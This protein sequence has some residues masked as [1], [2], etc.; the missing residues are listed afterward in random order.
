[1]AREIRHV[2][3]MAFSLMARRLRPRFERDFLHAS[4]LTPIGQTDPE[5]IFV[6]GYPKSGNTWFQNLIA[7]LVFGVDLEYARDT[8]VQELTPD[9]HARLYYKRF[10]VPMYFKSHHLPCPE[11]RRVIYLLRD[12]RDALVSYYH[13]LTAMGGKEVDLATMISTGEGLFPSKW[14]EHVTAWLANPYQADMMVVK[15]EDLMD[16]GLRQ[17]SK[18]CEFANIY[19]DERAIT[20]ALEDA[21]FSNMRHREETSG[22]DDRG[23]WPSDKHFVRRGKIGSYK[24]EMPV[25][26]Q[27][28]FISQAGPVLRSCGY[29][30]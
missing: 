26:V 4:G 10:Q 9:V 24:D 17:L 23:A 11:Y 12:G 5:D 13:Y 25:D 30:V 19:R 7:G 20:K 18:V 28:A 15:Y 16:S 14:H 27:T 2:R 21:S 22:W 1:M 8:F 6:V 3:D 29:A